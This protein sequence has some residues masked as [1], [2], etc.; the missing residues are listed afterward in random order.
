MGS[1][2]HSEPCICLIFFS[3]LQLPLHSAHSFVSLHSTSF[4][5]LHVLWGLCFHPSFCDCVFIPPHMWLCFSWCTW[6]LSMCQGPV[7]MHT[8]IN[9]LLFPTA[10]LL[11]RHC[12][13]PYFTD[14]KIKS[15]YLPKIT[16]LIG[17]ITKIQAWAVWL[18]SPILNHLATAAS[19]LG[20]DC[21]YI[22]PSGY[23]HT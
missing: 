4:C 10:N 12:D 6:V 14:E 7:H 16:Q 21:T 19:H 3:I 17:E 9:S 18:Q 23:V 1:S 2:P 20:L 11:S 15:P 22:C 13:H 8:N 5:P